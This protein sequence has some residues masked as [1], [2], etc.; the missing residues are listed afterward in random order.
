MPKTTKPELTEVP[1]EVCV[2]HDKENYQI[3]I[4]LPGVKKED[5]DLE[6]GEDALCVRAPKEDIVYSACYSLAHSVDTGKVSARFNDGLLT[7]KAAF[8]H[9]IHVGVKVPIE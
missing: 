1:P 9:P 5:I 4:E 8:K 7:I 2:D 3:E 6:V